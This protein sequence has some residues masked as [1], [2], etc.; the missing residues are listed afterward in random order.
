MLLVH[1]TGGAVWDPLP[2]LLATAGYRAIYYNRRG[3]GASMCPPIKDPP[4]HTRYRKLVNS[5]FT[6]RMIA[7]LE[8]RIRAYTTRTL[9]AVA[10]RGRCDLVADIAAELP[11]FAIAELVGIP[12]GDRH[13]IYE[14]GNRLIATSDNLTDLDASDDVRIEFYQYANW[15]ASQK[16]EHPGDDLLSN[17]IAAELTEGDG[18]THALSELEVDLFFLLL[19]FAGNETTR[20]A[21]THGVLAFDAFPAERDLLLERPEII[22]SAVEEILRWASPVLHI[23][24]RTIRKGERVV[25]WY[26]SAN[27]DE[28]VFDEPSR[29]DITR[30]PNEHVAFGGGGAHFCLGANLARLELKVMFEELYRRLPDLEPTGDAEPSL[31]NFLRGTT[32]LPVRF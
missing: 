12:E 15:L 1:G 19:T 30:D 9:D 20:N 3:F 18:S 31:Q 13:R 10:E 21:I 28:E 8:P 5:V 17:L 6:P 24:D 27:R 32:R 16:R 11:L 2:E 22:G 25:L 14:M 7:S 29:F 26:L 23:R 4:R